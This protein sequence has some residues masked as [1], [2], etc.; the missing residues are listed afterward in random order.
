MFSIFELEYEKFS[1]SE[2]KFKVCECESCKSFCSNFFG[3]KFCENGERNSSENIVPHLF[4]NK[5]KSNITNCVP[6]LIAEMVKNHWKLIIEHTLLF[7]SKIENLE[8]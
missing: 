2:Y 5:K 7:K 4:S 6:H 8:N 3:F 1:E